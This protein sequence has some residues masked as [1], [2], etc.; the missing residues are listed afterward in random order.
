MDRSISAKP[1]WQ[2]F[3]L[4]M[5]MLLLTACGGGGS[6]A[7]SAPPT[8]VIRT[9]PADVSVVAGGAATFTVVAS[10]QS[11][12]YQWQISTDDGASW[13]D[14][15]GATATGYHLASVAMGD[16]G[17]WF[18]VLITAAGTTVTS[19]AARLTVTAAPVAPAISVQPANQTVTEP[20]T[21][22]F[23]VTA[24]GTALHYQWQSSAD[25]GVTWSDISGATS[26]SYTTPATAAAASGTQLHVV[27]SN[28]ADT[29]TSSAA[30]LTINAAPSTNTAPAFTAQPADQSVAEGSAATFSA[31]VSGTPAPGLQ[32]QRSNDAAASWSDIPGATSASYTTSATVAA[33]DGAQFRLVATNSEGSV[34]SNAA[35]LTVAAASQPAI[36]TQPQ[37]STV[38]SGN[39]A[40]FSAAASG[41]PTPTWQWQLSTDGGTSW[42][43][44]T[45]ATSA[46]YTTPATATGDNGNR[47]RAVASNSEGS[48]TSNAV[49]LTVRA[50][51][52]V[53]LPMTVSLGGS[54][55]ADHFCAIKAD[56]T[57]AC[58]GYNNYGELGDGTN[59]DRSTPVAVLG[60]NN[61]VALSASFF[62]HTCALRADGTVWCWGYGFFS[63]IPVMVSVTDAVSVSAGTD[64]TCAL[65]ADG[66]VAC[67]GDNSLNQLGDGSLTHAVAI[68]AGGEHTCALK[69]DGT[70][71]CWGYNSYGQLGDGTTAVSSAAPRTVSG[72]SDA[73]A[74]SSGGGHTCALRAVGTVV[75]WGWNANGQLGDGSFGSS[76][77]RSTPVVV[78]G[79]AGVTSISAGSRHT[80][81][82]KTDGTAMCWGD[83]G[84]GQLGIGSRDA[85]YLKTTPQAVVNLSTAVAVAA[86][87][88]NSC[89]LKA[90]GSIV[91]WGANVHG[92]L[93][94]GS[95]ELSFSPIPV[96]GG[97]VFWH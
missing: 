2:R 50:A 13:T 20:A 1:A 51:L 30:T 72:L 56:K 76:N 12:V 90:D 9:Q 33:D 38:V 66:T 15:A 3:M 71:A 80:C 7:E 67:W 49:T 74:I 48:A 75:C 14:L 29:V 65:K 70:V 43:N 11:P 28:T 59:T 92:G 10:G 52:A 5:G 88:G 85:P 53:Q 6:D 89:A 96:S 55:G 4:L 64:H 58:W 91:C 93:G 68:S 45:G 97:A 25:G 40:T 54:G 78:S 81:A 24:S 87:E 60:I 39:T 77:N 36:T 23:S 31:T 83:N 32:W 73:V 79:L 62:G 47:Y 35:M 42:S 22:T 69:D 8:P 18:R 19:S 61:V 21:A 46:S 44:I 17:Q 16:S 94:D 26:S 95:T 27:V 82:L 84:S 57:A 63:A 34:P 41:T 86:G 37:D